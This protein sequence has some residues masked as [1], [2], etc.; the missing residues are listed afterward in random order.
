MGF[1][2]FDQVKFYV[3]RRAGSA[4]EKA[5][6]ALGVC[7]VL[8]ERAYTADTT[9]AVL[10]GPQ[11]QHQMASHEQATPRAGEILWVFQVSNGYLGKQFPVGYSIVTIDSHV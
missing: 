7:R 9:R 5:D 3:R 6:F 11:Y 10:N 1:L 8:R 4:L 2:K